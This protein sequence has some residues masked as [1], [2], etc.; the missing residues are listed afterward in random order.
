MVL[1]FPLSSSGYKYVIY[2]TSLRLDLL[3]PS[4]L[5]L[6]DVL[7][8]SLPKESGGRLYRSSLTLLF[9]TSLFRTACNGVTP[10][11]PVGVT[12]FQYK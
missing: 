9:E 3:T 7:S 1:P 6:L 12:T 8:F 11:V 2:V 5:V 10:L 4:S